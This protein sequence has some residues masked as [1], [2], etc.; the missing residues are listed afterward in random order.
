MELL[1]VSIIFWYL[2][3][4]NQIHFN[5]KNAFI[6]TSSLLESVVFASYED[7]KD[8]VCL[9]NLMPPNFNLASHV[10]KRILSRTAELII[11]VPT[12]YHHHPL[13]FH[14]FIFPYILFQQHDIDWTPSFSICVEFSNG[15]GRN[16]E[17]A[18]AKVPL[19]SG[20]CPLQR[21]S[22]VREVMI[23]VLCEN[24]P[25]FPN[26]IQHHAAVV[27]LCEILCE[28]IRRE[29]KYVASIYTV[30]PD[31]L[32]VD[33]R[34][35][36]NDKD[37]QCDLNEREQMQLEI[38]S[39]LMQ[40]QAQKVKKKINKSNTATYLGK[41]EE[42]DDIESQEPDIETLLFQ[43]GPST[44]EERESKEVK[45]SL[46]IQEQKAFKW[47]LLCDKAFQQENSSF[48][49]LQRVNFDFRCQN[50][51]KWQEAIKLLF[52]NIL[53]TRPSRRQQDL[54]LCGEIDLWSFCDPT[55]F[56]L[57]CRLEKETKRLREEYEESWDERK[58]AYD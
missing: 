13:L 22:L 7:K 4:I 6:M 25:M 49:N 12:V 15:N 33:G 8:Q 47:R 36:R 9:S 24:E 17:R 39:I 2:L 29:I 26:T 55:N 53:M 40:Y 38:E 28:N 42:D 1:K 27:A 3:K 37:L 18:L 56:E 58:V 46:T 51:V 41:M 48:L 34:N 43:G 30:G 20:L 31:L 16:H 10:N 57:V 19:F 52:S 50:I 5:V 44:K 14:I 23:G 11:T 32:F 54:I 45:D 35:A 21:L